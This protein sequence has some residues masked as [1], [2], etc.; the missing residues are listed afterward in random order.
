MRVGLDRIPGVRVR[1]RVGWDGKGKGR[2]WG[3]TEGR[4]KGWGRVGGG[5]E[6]K[7]ENESSKGKMGRDEVRRK[8]KEKV[9]I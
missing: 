9:K 7:A 8:M 6:G 1:G 2:G 4:R 3:M 5:E